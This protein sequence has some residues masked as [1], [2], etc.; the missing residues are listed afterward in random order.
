MKVLVCGGRDYSDRERVFAILDE[1]HRR[2]NITQI[3]EGGARGADAL[4]RDWANH[5]GVEV[6]TFPADWERYGKS[7]GFRR[8]Q[9]ML[10]EGQS[11]GAVVFPGGRGTADMQRRAS[12]VIQTLIVSPRSEP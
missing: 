6:R 1:L 8:N 9:Q 2:H 5:R 11:D 12:A 7:A 4:A 10:D 3:I